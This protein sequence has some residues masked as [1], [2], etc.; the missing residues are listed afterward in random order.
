MRSSD[1]GSTSP[2][3]I[4]AANWKKK[5]AVADVILGFLLAQPT[6]E[7]PTPRSFWFEHFF[8]SHYLLTLTPST[9]DR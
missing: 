6:L 9:F 7:T 4:E 5:R 1:F 8:I 3:K 2:E